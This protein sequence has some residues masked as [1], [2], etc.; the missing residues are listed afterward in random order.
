[1]SPS[2]YSSSS[3]LLFILLMCKYF[4][5]RWP[6]SGCVDWSY[7]LRHLSHYLQVD[8]R[9][10]C[11]LHLLGTRPTSPTQ[12]GKQLCVLLR[13]GVS[14]CADMATNWIILLS[15][16]CMF[17][18]CFFFFFE[19]KIN[20]AFVFHSLMVGWLGTAPKVYLLCVRRKEKSRSLQHSPD[21]SM[22]M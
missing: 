19:M 11:H 18:N 7:W 17:C 6:V 13:G 14:V 10:A 4:L 1:M 2:I 8:Q 20:A 5:N 15:V 9:G 3:S 12:T 21:V 16:I 22:K